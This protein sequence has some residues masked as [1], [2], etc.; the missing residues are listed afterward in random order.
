[1]RGGLSNSREAPTDDHS[2][3]PQLHVP[4]PYPLVHRVIWAGFTVAA[5]VLLVG[6]L[7]VAGTLWA[8]PYALF[9]LLG[10]ALFD[11]LLVKRG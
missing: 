3:A 2:S 1:M 4:P 6:A 9:L 7:D 11:W 10:I 5:A 8:L